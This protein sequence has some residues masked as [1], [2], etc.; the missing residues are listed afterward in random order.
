MRTVSIY[1]MGI[2]AVILIGCGKD[3]GTNTNNSDSA[4]SNLKLNNG[5][6]T[7]V[8]YYSPDTSTKLDTLKLSFN[9]NPSKVNLM[10]VMITLDSEKN[11][12]E[13][14]S[15]SAN[16]T[17]N[18]SVTFTWVPANADTTIKNFFGRKSCLIK[19]S[20]DAE[21]IKTEEFSLIGALSFISISPQGGE[22]FSATD[23]IHVL[24][25]QN[26]DLSA[27]ISVCF[28][29]SCSDLNDSTCSW[30]QTFGTTEKIS[31]NLPIKNFQLSFV[32]QDLAS[33]RPN[34]DLKQPLRILLAD[35]GTNGKRKATGNITIQN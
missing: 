20:D 27:N 21:Q 10:K 35:Y 11:W 18:S 1:L 2:F 26:Q 24:Y 19:I 32:P 29:T 25:S 8:A 6:K 7:Y 31:Q 9:C 16:N 4:F 15:I 30:E 14:D 33:D 22:T 28:S 13:I 12:I 3:N 5:S 23:T 34:I 17:N